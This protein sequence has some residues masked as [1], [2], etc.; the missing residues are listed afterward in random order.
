V[1]EVARHDPARIDAV[2]DWPL[3]DLFLAFAERMRQA[4]LE[5]YRA[6]LLVWAVL[7]PYQKR[8]PKPPAIPS[9]LK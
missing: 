7:A 4:A 1:R 6:E 3:R 8:P 2:L 5:R 9:I